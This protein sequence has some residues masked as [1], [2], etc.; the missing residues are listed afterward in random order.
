MLK[1]RFVVGL[2]ST[3]ALGTALA[4][5]D[6]AGTSSWSRFDT[7]KDGLISKEEAAS[8]HGLAEL[9]DK[10]DANKDG[11]LDQPELAAIHG[12]AHG[13][14]DAHPP[15]GVDKEHGGAHLQGT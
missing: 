11:Q 12:G 15:G 6:T 3:L 8:M 10:I 7:N 5:A 2:I 14:G 13:H 4:G 9:F 1:C